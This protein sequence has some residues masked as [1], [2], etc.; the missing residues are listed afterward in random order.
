V[1]R[2]ASPVD[3]VQKSAEKLGRITQFFQSNPEIMTFF[4][5]KALK[6]AR[7]ASL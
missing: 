2:T 5:L 4:G 1:R 7:R 3:V 6:F